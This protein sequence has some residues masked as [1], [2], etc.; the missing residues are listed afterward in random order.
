MCARYR[1]IPTKGN[2]KLK[3]SIACILILTI[4]VGFSYNPYP[5][6]ASSASDVTALQNLGMLSDVSDSALDQDLSR[7]IGLVMVMK[8][9]GYTEA[10]AFNAGKS[11]AF[12]DMQGI[13]SWGIGW[14]NLGVQLGITTG[15]SSDTFSP[16]AT[17]TKKAFLS[18]VLR[19]LGYSQDESWES[20]A[21]LSV[22]AGLISSLGAVND[23]DFSKRDAARIVYQALNADMKDGTAFIQSLVDRG[24][25]AED[26]A[27]N[28]NFAGVNVAQMR[29]VMPVTN[30]R[31]EVK[32][33]QPVQT[34]DASDFTIFN[35][36]GEGIDIETADLYD[37][38]TLVVLRT[39]DQ[40]EYVDHTITCE[41]ISLNYKAAEMDNIRPYLKDIEVINDH[42]LRVYYNDT[43]NETALDAGLYDI[44]EETVET[45]VYDVDDEGDP[46]KSQIILTTS[47]LNNKTLYML[48]ISTV[49]DLSWNRIHTSYD[50]RSFKG[51]LGDVGRPALSTLT[52]MNDRVLRLRFNEMM[53]GDTVR[54]IDNYTIPGLF[55]ESAQRLADGKTVYLTTSAQT[56]DQSYTLEMNG[57]KDLAGNPLDINYMSKAFAGGS[58][59]ILRPKLVSAKSLSSTEVLVTFGEAVTDETAM[60]PVAYDL[61]SELGMAIDVRKYDD[62][63]KTWVITTKSQ[64]EI[65]YTLD[66]TGIKDYAGNEVNEDADTA[67]FL[68]TAAD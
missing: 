20:C 11:S 65:T 40:D 61:G 34:I 24:V 56:V 6:Y 35:E 23:S 43:M 36:K 30:N 55:V 47:D 22:A 19:I 46:I 38:G 33:L 49:Y 51:V 3:K 15:T 5:I 10:D 13:I 21:K 57:L 8:M 25:V 27:R 4:M 29:S 9:I 44:E 18:Y 14:V 45:A 59:D 50:S 17:L 52:V 16:E 2:N 7:L 37:A 62:D 67:Q 26:A 1:T 31:L 53:D 42:K 63:G 64:Y 32:L 12:S 54:D 68:G 58:E 28:L 60:M 48:S 39:D 41:G 66:V